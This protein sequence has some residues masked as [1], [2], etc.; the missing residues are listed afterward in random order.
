MVSPSRTLS[1]AVAIVVAANYAVMSVL[2][3]PGVNWTGLEEKV[4]IIRIT[5]ML[6]V[7]VAANLMHRAVD[8][9]Q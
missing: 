5:A 4:L 9:R 7:V 6:A 2:T 3:E 1:F 8:R